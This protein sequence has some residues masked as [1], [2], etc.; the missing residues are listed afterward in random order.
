[1]LF[2][3]SKYR[4][5]SL[6]ALFLPHLCVSIHTVVS[7]NFSTTESVTESDLSSGGVIGIT[8]GLTL[9]VA[10]PVGVVLGQDLVDKTSSRWLLQ[11]QQLLEEEEEVKRA[12]SHL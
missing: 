1:M 10:L 3:S 2:N 5:V 12:E 9:L 4:D 8:A 6:T 11:S 7:G